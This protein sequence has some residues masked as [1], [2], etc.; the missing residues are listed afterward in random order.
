MCNYIQNEEN[1]NDNTIF[2]TNKGILWLNF[3]E[4]ILFIGYI[5]AMCNLHKDMIELSN[6]IN[7][8]NM[9]VEHIES[10]L[11]DDIRDMP[12]D[13]RKIPE[14]PRYTIY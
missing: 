8:I 11:D 13:P 7:E 6:I 4:C 3:F 10:M 2:S 5:I 9:R 1:T 14:K 12:D